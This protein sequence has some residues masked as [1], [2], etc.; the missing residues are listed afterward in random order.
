[1]S[2]ALP[3]SFISTSSRF[4]LVVEDRSLADQIKT[5]NEFESNGAFKQVDTLSLMHHS[6][7]L[8]L[9]SAMFKARSQLKATSDK[10]KE[11]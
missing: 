1:M 5:W 3:L 4:K 2:F 11:K 7:R 8:A 10:N 6:Y 9:L